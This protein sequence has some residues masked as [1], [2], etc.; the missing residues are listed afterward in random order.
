[1]NA[2]NRIILNTAVTYATLIIKMLIGFFSVRLI[3]L[4]LGESDYGVYTIVAGVAGLLDILNGNMANTS[5]RYMA[6]SLGS[7]NLELIKKTFS[8]TLV[9]HYFVGLITILIMEIGGWLMFNYLLDIPADRFSD[10]VIIYQFMI[11]TTFVSIIAVPY[12]AVMNAH[13]HIWILSLFDILSAIL[14][15]AMALYLF[16]GCGDKLL[17]YGLFLMLIQIILRIMKYLYSRRNYIECQ[18]NSHKYFDKQLS[19]DILSFTGWNFFGSLA[20][21]GATQF[22]SII[23]N[24]FFGVR[25]NAAEG[26]S[27]QASGYVNMFSTSMTRAINPQ[28]MKSEGGGDHQR[29]IYVTEIGSKYSSF[30]FALVGVPIAMEAD[31]L[32]ELWLKD[33]PQY[34]VIFC[35]LIMTQ[36]LIEKFTFQITHAIRAVG[37][38]RNFQIVESIACLFYLP[39]AYI[40]FKMGYSPESI[41][42]LGILN[43]C[44]VAGVRL[45]FGRKIAKIEIIQFLRSSVLPVVSPLAISIVLYFV[46]KGLFISNLIS[47]LLRMVSFCIVFIMLFYWF[48]LNK[49]E[50]CKWKEIIKS[51]RNKVIKRNLQ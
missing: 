24:M 8:T 2:A 49:T 20:S 35:Q 43:S 36:M 18:N 3:L 27:R 16:Y 19:K 14:N 26:V 34:A 10:A 41:Y 9:I 13:E 30:L 46:G 21:L 29:M 1:M 23:I 12:D 28:I 22:R 42:V 15:L 51:I 25:L 50:R 7:N 40:F 6:H 5:M 38:I 17:L 44:I 47:V 31:F 37:D 48:G 32:L 4:A 39:F 33:V 11:A 45:Y